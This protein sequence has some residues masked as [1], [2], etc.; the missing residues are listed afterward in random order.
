MATLPDKI[1]SATASLK[2]AQILHL[3]K[4]NQLLTAAIVFIAWQIGIVADATTYVG[5]MC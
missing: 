3:V 1:P 5:G 2:L 4:E